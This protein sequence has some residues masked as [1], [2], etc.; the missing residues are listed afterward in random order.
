MHLRRI[1]FSFQYYTPFGS[2]TVTISHTHYWISKQHNYPEL[3]SKGKQ[4]VKYCS[5]RSYDLTLGNVENIWPSVGFL[6]LE[7]RP[8]NRRNMHIA[9]DDMAG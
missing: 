2:V 3:I 9:Q 5:Y 8:N 1:K 6:I 7:C 4:P